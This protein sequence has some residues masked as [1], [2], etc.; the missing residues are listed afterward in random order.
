MRPLDRTALV[1][2]GAVAAVAAAAVAVGDRVG[3]QVVAVTPARGAG[4]V[5]TLA[6]IEVRFSEPVDADGRSAQLAI[7]P[8]IDGEARWGTRTLI[9]DPDRPLSARTRYTVRLDGALRAVSGR[10]LRAPVEWS[11]ATGALQIAYVTGPAA[12]RDVA[13]ARTRIA[14]RTVREGPAGGPE[15][16]ERTLASFERP[17]RDFHRAP[18]GGSLVATLGTGGF[19]ADLWLIDLRDGGARELL[20]CGGAECSNA[21]WAPDGTAVVF[22]QRRLPLPPRPWLVDPRTGDNRPVLEEEVIGFDPRW[23]S[24]GAWVAFVSPLEG[25]LR[26]AGVDG[27]RT[28]LAATRSAAPAAWRPG[29]LTLLTSDLREG[30]DGQFA[31][32]II[33]ID[34]ADL[35]V[36][37]PL[38]AEHRG[39][40]S[41]AWAPD[42]ARFAF[43]RMADRGEQVWIATGAGG[44]AGA[45]A[46]GAP[47][48]AGAPPFSAAPLITAPSFTYREIVFSPGGDV[49]A[50]QRSRLDVPYPQP[51][52]VVFD[53][54]GQVVM[55]IAGAEMPRW[56]P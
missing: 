44:A 2:I 25:G 51:E 56:L 4:P 36:R 39:G 48:A 1:A 24:D 55:T 41:P 19:A 35:S 34:L 43:I 11:F 37:T 20:D 29:A 49:M 9:F 10:R 53:L 30:P 52:V 32:V 42:G 22:S 18:D 46:A 54:T 21:R 16:G 15:S 47:Q 31:D 45:G 27:G 23:S 38:G 40:R 50:V 7:E 14:A 33:S 26:I 13:S 6:R 5:S 8:P 17:V 3:L 12:A 28:V